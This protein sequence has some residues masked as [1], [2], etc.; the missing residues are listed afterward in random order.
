MVQRISFLLKER[1]KIPKYRKNNDRINVEISFS[2]NTSPEGIK[3]L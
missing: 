3:L 2:Q 1:D